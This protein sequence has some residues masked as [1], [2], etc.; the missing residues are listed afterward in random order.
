MVVAIDGPSGVGK[1]TVATTVADRLG[2]AYLDTGSTY[3]AATLITLSSG[4]DVCD[5]DAILA[6]LS[7]H[8]IDY[9]SEGVQIDGL[10]VAVDVRTG[11]VT[12]NV[13]AVSAH[14]R[15]REHIVSVQRDWVH[16]RGDAAV[17]EGRDIGTVVFPDAAVKVYLT[18]RPEI[19]A[20]RRAGDSEAAD[21][22][23]DEIAENLAARDR[24]DSTREASP[25][26]PADDAVIIDTSDIDVDGVVR[27]IVDLATS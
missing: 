4:I 24:A 19:R 8:T 15:V 18:A 14:P 17:V 13:S 23:I 16:R 25:L 10:R 7:T 12:A 21:S 20:L 27:L 22:S 6:E 5:E 26:R 11:E 1:S 3:R 9:G 2:L